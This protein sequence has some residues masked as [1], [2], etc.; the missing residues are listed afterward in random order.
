M[1]S[2]SKNKPTRAKISLYFQK[3]TSE[4]LKNTPHI[5]NVTYTYKDAPLHLQ[6]QFADAC[7]WI[8]SSAGIRNAIPLDRIIT[9][10]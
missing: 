4:R 10:V 5:Q 3:C 8:N 1:H 2:T 6:F 7:I 9:S